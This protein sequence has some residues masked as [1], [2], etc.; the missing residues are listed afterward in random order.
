MLLS[1]KPQG[2]ISV[3]SVAVIEG[4]F[5]VNVSCQQGNLLTSFNISDEYAQSVKEYIAVNGKVNPRL[6]FDN[7]TT[8]DITINFQPPAGI[9]IANAENDYIL[10]QSFIKA[11]GIQI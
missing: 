11:L 2:Q 8:Y 7:L 10:T 3:I 1:A 4:D 9:S 6:S 5:C